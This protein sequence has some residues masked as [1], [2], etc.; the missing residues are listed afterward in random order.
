M[1]LCLGI[2]LILEFTKRIG[3]VLEDVEEKTGER[4]NNL[5]WCFGAYYYFFLF[6]ESSEYF[7]MLLCNPFCINNPSYLNTAQYTRVTVNKETCIEC[8][9]NT[10]QSL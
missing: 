6:L 2:F 5:S 1:S 7:K 8:S 10:S 4:K 9:R 3:S